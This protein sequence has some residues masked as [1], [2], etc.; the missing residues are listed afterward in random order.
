MSASM[1]H[2]NTVKV[3]NHTEHHGD[4]AFMQIYS[5]PEHLAATLFPASDLPISAFV[6]FPIPS[7][8]S[9]PQAVLPNT[10]QQ[11]F[12]LEHPHPSTIDHALLSSLPIPTEPI[13]MALV[14]AAPEAWNAGKRSVI[15]AHTD[16]TYRYPFWLIAFWDRI[17]KDIIPP[18]MKWQAAHRFV[19]QQLHASQA[20]S[21]VASN[22]QMHLSMLPW[23]GNVC[24]F[25]DYSPISKLAQFASRSWLC[26]N[27][28]NFALE[29]ILRQIKSSIILAPFCDILQTYFTNKLRTTFEARHHKDYFGADDCLQLREVGQDIANGMKT[30]E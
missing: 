19:E 22:F 21:S 26:D 27:N 3:H 25:M 29:L 30:T 10:I 7:V 24:G 8:T 6:Q 28:I 11:Y 13:I 15:Y 16:S 18:L 14:R 17:A 23:E 20:N 5:V 4:V 9:A 1:S 12:C 2:A